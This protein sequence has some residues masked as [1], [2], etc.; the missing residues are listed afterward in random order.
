M[1]PDE[2]LYLPIFR[3]LQQKS[4]PVLVVDLVQKKVL[5][6][7]G[8]SAFDIDSTKITEILNDKFY[9]RFLAEYF[10]NE[11]LLKDCLLYTS[12]AADE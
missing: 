11:L 2:E 7:Y 4:N 6:K 1:I 8:K 10:G 3:A 12:D 9:F 5:G